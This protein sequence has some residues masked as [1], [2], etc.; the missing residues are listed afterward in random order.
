MYGGKYM[1]YYGQIKE[2]LLKCEIYDKV[3]DYSKNQNRVKVYF[4]IGELLSKAGR[5]YGK[6]IINQ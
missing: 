4:K 6:S 2:N 3:K 1:K 5:E